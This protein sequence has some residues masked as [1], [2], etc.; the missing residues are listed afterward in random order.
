MSKY[1]LIDRGTSTTW[2]AVKDTVQYT[3]LFKQWVEIWKLC[4][5]RG[6]SAI[7]LFPDDT[8]TV[9]RFSK[10]E[11]SNINLLKRILKLVKSLFFRILLRGT[12]C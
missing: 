1:S 9:T 3:K 5:R 8:I 11:K 10:T 7:F 6:H 4:S 2:S 12:N